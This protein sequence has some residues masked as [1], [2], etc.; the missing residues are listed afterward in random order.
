MCSWFF[1]L[2]RGGCRFLRSAYGRQ[3][4]AEEIEG[5]LAPLRVRGTESTLLRLS[6]SP[7]V[8]PIER[9]AALEFPVM[10]IWGENDAW[11]PSSQG[12][13]LKQAVTRTTYVEIAGAGHCPMETHFV[14]FNGLVLEF[15]Q[16]R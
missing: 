11:V 3:P 2:Y 1:R 10:A 6:R 7:Q 8:V 13:R 5:Y 14:E 12:H 9:I 16:G 4:Q 15:V